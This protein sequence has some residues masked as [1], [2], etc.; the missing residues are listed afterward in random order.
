M[1]PAARRRGVPALAMLAVL[2]AFG[3]ES[4]ALGVARAQEGGARREFQVSARKH[5]FTPS[6][7]EVQ[8]DDLVKITLR[9]EDIAH[10]FTI[11]D[12]RIAKRAGAGQTVI[13]EFRAD[14]AGEFPFYCNLKVDDGCRNMRGRLIVRPR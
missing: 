8:Q 11:D 6:T 4:D 2:A 14:R 10:S 9:A 5:S 13:F 1:T 3:L 7:L 12:Y